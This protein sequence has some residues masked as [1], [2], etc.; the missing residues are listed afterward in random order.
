MPGT[1]LS[2]T[3]GTSLYGCLLQAEGFIPLL[4]VLESR[5]GIT[6]RIIAIQQ[7]SYCFIPLSRFL[8]FHSMNFSHQSRPCF[9][10]SYVW[11]CSGPE[12]RLKGPWKDSNSRNRW[13]SAEFLISLVLKLSSLWLGPLLLP[14]R[15]SGETYELSGEPASGQRALPAP[16]AYKLPS[17][18]W[19]MRGGMSLN[20]HCHVVPG[21][22]FSFI[23]GCVQQYQLL[24]AP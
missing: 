18:Q 2:R 3:F 17:E 13:H 8:R 4:S 21:C 22:C 24:Q 11:I 16:S 12:R 7:L 5:R 6:T 14:S 10:P 1:R 15:H 9:W 20:F 19:S 23:R